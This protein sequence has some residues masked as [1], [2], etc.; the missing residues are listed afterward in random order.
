MSALSSLSESKELQNGVFD[1]GH[2]HPVSLI[3]RDSQ[4]EIILYQNNASDDLIAVK[5]SPLR[6]Y[7]IIDGIL[8]ERILREV[9]SLMKLRHPSIIPLLGYDL[10]IDSKILRIAMPYVGS[11]SLKTVLESPEKHPWLTLTAKTIIIVGIVIGMYVVH[12]SGIIHR[13]LKPAN[14]ILHQISHY[15]LITDFSL[16][17][18]EDT[19]VTMT[20]GIG[21]PLYMAPE[22]IIGERYSNKAD[23]FSFGVL[24]YETV[25]GKKPVQDCGGIAFRLFTQVTTGHREAIPDTVEPFT[26]GLI[27][28]CWDSD[29]ANRPTFL[30]IFDE[31]RGNRFK[32]FSTVDTQAVEQFLQSVS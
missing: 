9:K 16:S 28:R 18:E 10:Q 7:D 32:I 8:N 29:P 13:D 15:P 19:S 17:R 12:S 26:A 30:E 31:L 25:T 6:D 1:F 23:V 4:G 21:T 11:D 22:I 2:F 24:L 20:A 27:S 3:A 5:S 14:V